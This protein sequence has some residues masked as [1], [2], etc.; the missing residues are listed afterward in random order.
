M[1]IGYDYECVFTN[2]Y[3]GDCIEHRLANCPLAE[4]PAPHGRL[5]DADRLIVALKN[6]IYANTFFRTPTLTMSQIE[7]LIEHQPTI[8]DAEE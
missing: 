2:D 6:S 3:V 7:Q 5:I 8:I 4:V 1:A